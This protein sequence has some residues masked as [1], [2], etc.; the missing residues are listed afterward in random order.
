M[1]INELIITENLVR[2][3]ILDQTPWFAHE[4]LE[5]YAGI[6]TVNAIF[7]IG[8]KHYMRMP[9]LPEW[10]LDIENE[11]NILKMVEGR[12]SIK[13]PKPVFLGKPSEEYPLHWAIHEWIDGQ[14]YSEA[15]IKK[16]E[17]EA[18]RLSLFVNQMHSIKLDASVQKAGRKPLKD[19][20]G[21]TV[22]A[23]HQSRDFIDA[24]RTEKA[25]ESL[26]LA[27]EWDSDPVFIH[28]DLLRTNILAKNGSI[29]AV[30]DFGSSGAGDPAHDLIPAWTVFS[31]KGRDAF[32]NGVGLPDAVV[33]RAK[34]YALHQA[35]LIIPYYIKSYGYFSKLA[36]RT[37]NEILSETD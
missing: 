36:I 19:L 23:I 1:H 8:D 5:R 34:G 7:R 27:P 33:E 24:K 12:L 4:K 26:A 17:E 25:W 15:T 9:R 10:S 2:A 11:W 35:L 3:L 28:G 22:E 6:G 32:L 30:I 31:N 13:T 16:E 21:E 14:D 37:V 29:Y 18:R 20:Y